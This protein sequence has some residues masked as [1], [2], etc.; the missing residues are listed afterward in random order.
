MLLKINRF[1]FILTFAAVLA[2]TSCSSKLGYGVLLWSIEEPTILSGSV[3]PVYI[4]S[5]IEKVWIVGIP[6]HLVPEGGSDK[7]EVPLYQLEFAGNKRKANARAADFAQYAHTYAENMLDALP[8][9]D[10]TDNNARRVYRLRLGE[11]IK[12]LGTVQGNPPISGTGDP[13]P[14]DWLKVLT[15][16]GV[17]GYCFSY[18]LRLFEQ[19][20]DSVKTEDIEGSEAV[21]DADLD[22][23]LSTVWYTEAYQQMIDAKKVN[24]QAMERSYR[25]DPGHE[26]GIARIILPDLERQFRY[27]KIIPDGNRAWTFEGTNL[28]MIMNSNNSLTVQFTEGAGAR[29]NLQFVNLPTNIRNIISQESARRESEFKK[30][31]DQGPVF[32]STNYGTLTLISTGNFTWTGYELL[33]PQLFPAETNGTGRINMDLYV[34]EAFEDRYNGAFTLIFSDIR[35]NNT[36]YFM[37]GIDNQ[38][39]RLEVVP[40]SSIE[41]TTIVR[42]AASPMIF[43]FFKDSVQ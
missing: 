40:A 2:L 9:R 16:D 35:T 41:D 19:D 10:N 43:Y 24:V 32:S 20:N 5:N 14:G 17:I 36:F 22:M 15:S 39:L 33:V 12:V 3:L 23:V 34:S 27:Q 30:I 6:S 7:I 28:R 38:G 29:R 4:K 11:I 25:F 37:Y 1:T 18:R 26:T 42:R 13:L 21:N 31:F 8:I